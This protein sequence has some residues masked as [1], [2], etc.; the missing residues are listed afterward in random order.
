MKFRRGCGWV[1]RVEGLEGGG[2]EWEGKGVL[3]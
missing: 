1:K 2:F 3:M